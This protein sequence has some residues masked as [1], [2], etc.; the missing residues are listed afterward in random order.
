M[1]HEETLK[2]IEKRETDRNHNLNELFGMMRDFGDRF[3]RHMEAEEAAMKS[4]TKAINALAARIEE[5]AEV[6]QAFPLDDEGKRD[7]P[8]HRRD[9]KQRMLEAAKGGNFWDTLKSEASKL[10]LYGVMIVFVLGVNTYIE[11]KSH[12]SVT[13]VQ[14]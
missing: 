4:H 1:L 9:H 3:E 5:I 14:K 7:F 8:G 11:N 13:V 2:V 6:H 10:L 12:N